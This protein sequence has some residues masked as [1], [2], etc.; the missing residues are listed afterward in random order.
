MFLHSHSASVPNRSQPRLQISNG[1][2]R[3]SVFFSQ[4]G[5]IQQHSLNFTLSIPF[6]T[7][8]YTV[9]EGG[10]AG[11]PPL[12]NHLKSLDLFLETQP[13]NFEMG[14]KMLSQTGLILPLSYSHCHEFYQ[15]LSPNL[16]HELKSIFHNLFNMG[17]LT[18]PLPPIPLPPSDSDQTGRL[19][20]LDGQKTKSVVT[21]CMRIANG[22]PMICRPSFWDHRMTAKMVEEVWE[23]GV[24][25]EGVVFT[26][27]GLVESFELFLGNQKRDDDEKIGEAPKELIL[28]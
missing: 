10:P 1:H 12:V 27:S 19:S 7:Q 21:V 26:K 20:G 5:K 11:H 24:S 3:S 4:H 6:S 18:V 2:S 17:F 9:G 16:L 23:V 28:N 8:P 22:V 15:E 14:M 13:K 25:V